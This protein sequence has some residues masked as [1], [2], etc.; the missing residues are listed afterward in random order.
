MEELSPHLPF[1]KSMHNIIKQKMKY[2]Q[3]K[4]LFRDMEVTDKL[5]G[6]GVES[7]CFQAGGNGESGLGCVVLTSIVTIYLQIITQKSRLKLEKIEL[8]S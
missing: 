8:K 4:M 3:Y 1:Q 7:G 6:T 2:S 5:P